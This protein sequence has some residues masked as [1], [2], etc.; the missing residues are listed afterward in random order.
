M[1]INTGKHIFL[2]KEIT[3]E[4]NAVPGPFETFYSHLPVEVLV[5][6]FLNFFVTE[7]FIVKKTF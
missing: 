7:S 5:A 2:F 1:H 3:C 6:P 4:F